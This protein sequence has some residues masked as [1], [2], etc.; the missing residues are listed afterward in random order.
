MTRPIEVLTDSARSLAKG[1][2]QTRIQVQNKDELGALAQAF[3]DMASNLSANRQELTLKNEELSA[4]NENL[5]SMQEQLLRSER[6]AAIGQLAAGVSHEIDNPVG[7]ILGHAEL[8]LEDLDEKDPMRE[9]VKA[10]IEECRRCKRITGGLLGF[11]RASQSNYEAVDIPHLIQEAIASLR[12][13]KLFK[14]LELKVYT[15]AKEL[16]VTVDADQLRQV[17][18]NI[19]LNAAQAMHGHGKLHISLQREHDLILIHVDDSG[20]GIPESALEKVFQP[21]Y[22]TKA[23][24]EGTGLGLPL[25]RKLVEAQQGQIF[26][27]KSMLGG[28]KIT[29]TLPFSKHSKKL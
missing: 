27:Q 16:L 6:L 22:S 28:A 11:A 25:C 24:G 23:K 20:P 2:L 15:E 29:I 26:A 14:D 4:A 9:D 10:I 7:I 21:F 1:E 18:I 17:L 5:K 13:Q 19:F 3:N 12:P 8:M